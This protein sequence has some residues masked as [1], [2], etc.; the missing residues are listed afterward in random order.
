MDMRHAIAAAAGAL[1]LVAM[2]GAATA[3]DLPS[4]GVTIDDVVK[5]LQGAGYRAEIQTGDDGSKNVYSSADGR[6]FHIYL[7]DCKDGRCGS[8]QF[9][10]GFDTKGAFSADKMNDWNRDSRWARAYVDKS[11][12]PWVEYDVD[13]TPGG[14]YELLDDEFGT[15]RGALGRFYKFIGWTDSN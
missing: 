5:W 12:D 1:L 7:Y 15:W 8:L 13:L 2:S 4:G 3:K 14:T 10:T 9:S 11:N 6:N